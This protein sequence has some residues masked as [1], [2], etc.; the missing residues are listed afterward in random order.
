MKL[1]LTRMERLSARPATGWYTG[2]IAPAAAGVNGA[3]RWPVKNWIPAHA[4]INALNHHMG[5]ASTQNLTG[6]RA[7]TRPLPGAR[8]NTKKY[9]KTAHPANG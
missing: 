5:G 4:G 9:I 8:G 7:F 1:Q 3:A 6:T 2:A